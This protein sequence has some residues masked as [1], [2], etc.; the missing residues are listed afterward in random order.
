[1][2]TGLDDVALDAEFLQRRVRTAGPFRHH[3]VARVLQVGDAHLAGPE[4]RR[5]EVAE[6]VEEAGSEN[7][8]SVNS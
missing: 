8:P 4:S 1:M 7:G 6:A 5:R 3:D 2:V